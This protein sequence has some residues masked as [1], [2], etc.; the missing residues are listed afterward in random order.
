MK[1]VKTQKRTQDPIALCIFEK[2]IT[3]TCRSNIS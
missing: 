3:A 1:K 2:V